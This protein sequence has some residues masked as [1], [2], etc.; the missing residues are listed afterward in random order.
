MI[1]FLCRTDLS[2]KLNMEVFFH[3]ES[4]VFIWEGT[5]SFEVVKEALSEF[6]DT[7]ELLDLS[8]GRLT[9]ADV[10]HVEN[11]MKEICGVKTWNHDVTNRRF[12]G[13]L[14]GDYDYV[15]IVKE[16]IIEANA[17]RDEALKAHLVAV[18]D[19][20]AMLLLDFSKVKSHW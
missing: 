5:K 16:L 13:L 15:D 4:C 10:D 19:G 17:T 6:A 2:E 14:K 9:D 7:F 12:T 3:A 11:K 8:T 1:F 20:H 18:K